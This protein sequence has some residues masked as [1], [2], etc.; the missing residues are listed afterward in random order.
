MH[1]L[2][3]QDWANG[4]GLAGATADPMANPAG[5]GVQNLMKYAF[6]LSPLTNNKPG[7]PQFHFQPFTVGQQTGSYLTVQFLRQLGQ[8]NLTYVVE[9]S[10]DLKNWSPLCTAA[11]ANAPGGPGF[12][13][14]SGTGYQRQDVV[15]DTVAA[16]S[17]ATT[18]FVG[19]N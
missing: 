16:E 4:Y 17:G 5:D 12:V 8:S 9:S 7:L 2:S 1:P 19:S 14:E 11:G 13:S 15:R 18:R 10:T 6:N 3:Y